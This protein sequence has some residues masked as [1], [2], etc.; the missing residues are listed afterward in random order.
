[1]SIFKYKD[2]RV[3]LIYPNVV[4]LKTPMLY[5]KIQPQ[6]FLGEKNPVIKG[7]IVQVH[8]PDPPAF[9]ARMRVRLVIKRLRVRTPPGSTTFFRGDRS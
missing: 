7:L 1:M 5:V 9:V 2:G 6:S 8:D 4:D 3:Y